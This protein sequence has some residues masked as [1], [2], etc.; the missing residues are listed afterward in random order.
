MDE[1]T[2]LSLEPR[3]F[4]KCCGFFKD[5]V[6]Y[7]HYTYHISKLQCKITVQKH[8][9]IYQKNLS[10]ASYIGKPKK[11]PTKPDFLCNGPNT[12]TKVKTSFFQVALKYPS[13]LNAAALIHLLLLYHKLY[14]IHEIPPFCY[15][16]EYS[17]MGFQIIA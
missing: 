6:W 13:H 7:V 14:T 5:I 1:S 8:Y 10:S 9:K 16:I 12:T 11:S 17:K 4:S 2:D 3:Q 15:Y